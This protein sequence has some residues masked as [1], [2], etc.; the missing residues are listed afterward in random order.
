M[1]KKILVPLD[2]SKFSE[3][4]LEHVA[5]IA[6][7]CHV[8]E[9]VLLRVVE[10]LRMI[11]EVPDDWLKEARTKSLE[12]AGNYLKNLSAEM[13]KAGISASP[14]LKE[15]FPDQVILDYIRDKDIDLV[16]MSS[17]GQSGITRWAMGSVADR[18]VRNSPAPVMVVTPKGCRA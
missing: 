14:E 8:P 17:K 7:G 16:M 11:A 18:V 13:G 10:P 4:V 12:E 2:G 6:A 3:C 9:V 15:G 1:Y 5:A